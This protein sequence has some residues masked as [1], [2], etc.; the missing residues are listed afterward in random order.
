MPAIEEAKEIIKLVKK[1]TSSRDDKILEEIDN[2]NFRIYEEFSGKKEFYKEI[3]K[4]KPPLKKKT[5]PEPKLQKTKSQKLMKTN[6]KRLIRELGIDEEILKRMY[7]KKSKRKKTISP[8]FTVYVPSHLGSLANSMF[9]NTVENLSK[10]HPAFFNNLFHTVRASGMSLLSK[11]YA[12]IMF[13]TSVTSAV[14]SFFLMLLILFSLQVNPIIALITPIFISIFIGILT[15]T[16]M[17]MYPS[18]EAATKARAI[19]NNLPFAIIHMSAVAGSGAQPISVF[20]LLLNSR[21]YKG[22]ESEIKKIVNYVNLFGYDLST[23]L[24]TVS[25]TTPSKRFKDLL[26]GI[27][28][29]IESGGSLKSYLTSMAD[30]T[31]TTYKLER[32]KY[33]EILSTYS[34]IYTGILIAAPLLFIVTLAIINLMGGTIAGMPISTIAILGTFGIIPLLNIVFYLFLT[35]TQP[36]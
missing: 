22:L 36:G 16:L 5:S 25:I 26:N 9:K 32:K 1:Y 12:S 15:F 6:K 17:Y 27:A 4:E 21:E 24:K 31:M 33:V 23:A 7:K 3:I 35:I 19:D 14:I 18:A 34:D 10:K 2:A 11:T 13:L 30:D 28:A 29:T 20:K 8:D